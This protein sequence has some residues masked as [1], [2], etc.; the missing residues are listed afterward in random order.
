MRTKLKRLLSLLLCLVLVLNSVPLSVFAADEGGEAANAV[1]NGEYKNGTWVAGGDGTITYKGANGG[2][3][4]VLS[5]TAEITDINEFEITLQV[6]TSQTTEKAVTSAGAVVL[7]ID[8]SSSMK[9][10]AECGERDYHKSS[11]DYYVSSSSGRPGSQHNNSPVKDGQRRIDAAKEAAK[12]FLATYAGSDATADRQL[13]IVTF[14]G[15][16]RTN[17]AWANVAGGEGKNSYNTAASTINGLDCETGTIMDGGLYLAK[18]LLDDIDVTNESVVLLSDGAPSLRM[19]GGSL[20]EEWRDCEAAAAQAK[21]IRET[22]K[23]TLYTVCFGAAGQKIEDT[24]VTVDKFLEDYIA[25]PG[26]AYTAD[27]SAALLE[28]FKTIAAQIQ[29]GPL[30]GA[31]VTD[32]MGGN[33]NAENTAAENF[34]R[35]ESEDGEV[36]RWNLS[37]PETTTTT[38]GN[39][40]T[41][42]Y[43]YTC[44]YTVTLDTDNAAFEEGVF[45]PTNGETY[46]N[47]G[48]KQYAFPVP[49]VSGVETKVSVGVTKLWDDGDDQDGLRP[50]DVTV[51]LYRDGKAVEGKTLTITPNADGKWSGTFEDLPKYVEKK[52]AEYTVREVKTAEGYEATYGENDEGLVITNTHAPEQIS[53]RATKVWE[54]NNDQDGIRPDSIT[55]NLVK[56]G[57]VLESL[58][59]T[60][61]NDWTV[62]FSGY[63]KY[64]DGEEIEYTV[65]EDEVPGYEG[66]VDGYVITNT[67]EPEV[68]SVTVAKVW[69]DADNQDGKRPNDV[70][71][72]LYA[73][74]K[75]TGKTLVLNEGNEWAASFTELDKFAAGEAIAYTVQELTVEGYETEISGDMAT[76]FTITNTHIPEVV[77]VSGAKTWNDNNDQDGARPDSITINLKADGEIIETIT[78]TEEDEW[79]WSFTDLPKYEAGKLITYSITEEAVED[80]ST[81]YNGYDVTNTHT[82]EKIS[83]TVTKV[84]NDNNNQD[85]IRANSVT[86]VLMANGEETDKTLVLS[87]G[88][89]W[90]GSFTELDK[91]AAGEEIDYTVQELTVEGYE[92][93]ITGDMTTGFTITNTHTPE[94]T[95]VSGS[96]TW[97][98]N[99]DQDGARPDS[100]TINLLKN[101][102]VID[103]K[104]VTA[105]DAWSWSFTDLPKFENHGTEIVY[106]I[107]EVAV[108]GYVTEYNGFNV[109][110][111]HAPEKTSITVTKSWQDNND[112]DGIRPNDVT[113]ALLANDEDTGKT[114]VLNE[115][116]NWTGSFAELDK[117]ENGVEIKYTIE[118]FEV[119]G[120]N[121]VITGNRTDGYTITNSHTPATV[122]VSGTKTWDDADNQ[123]GK[124]P[125]S[126]TINLVV[127]D[128]VIDT[129]TVTAADKWSWSFTNLPK[130]ENHGSEIVYS[131]NET[132]VEH[133]STNY[134]GYNVTNSYTPEQTSITV[135]KSWQDNNDQDGIRPDVITVKLLADKEETGK[136]LE[137]T[138]ANNWTGSFTELDV[139]ANGQKIVYTVAE[140][141]VEKYTTVITGTAENGFVVT[142]SYTP[143]TT[144]V[145]GTKTW[146]DADDQDGARPD[147][148]TIKLLADGEVINTETVTEDN[149]WSWSFTN[150]PKYRDGGTEIV[151]A[152]TEVA[153]DKYTTTYDGYNVTNSY[154]PE[155]TG[156]TVSKS[157]QDS[158]NQD[159]IRPESVTVVLLANGEETDKTLTLSEGNKWTGTFTELDKYAAGE[160]IE[161]K[162]QELAVEGYETVISGDQYEGY[163]VTNS[164]TPETTEVSGSKTWNDNNDQDGA[165][166]DSITIHLLANGKEVDSVTV[167]AA[168]GWSWTFENLPKNEN[169]K[170]INYTVT[171]TAVEDYSTTVNGYNVTNTHTPEQTSVQVTKGW[172]DANNQDGIRPSSVT[173]KLLAN[174]KDTGKTVVLTASNKWTGTFTKLDVYANGQKIVYTVKEISVPGYTTVVSGN[175][176][177]GFVV[178]NS[179]T[180]ELVEVN[181]SKTWNDNNNQD[182]KRPN[183]IVIHLLANGKIV[184]TKVVTEADGW[185]WTFENLPKNENGKAINYT[186]L[187]DAV[188]EYVTTY[189]GY[190]VTNTHAPEK[191]AV[192]VL[193]VWADNDD[194]DGI[195]P[196]DVT[197]TLYANGKNTGKT[198]VLSEGNAW[199][200]TFVNLDKYEN[201]NVIVYTVLETEVEDYVSVIA[202][203]QTTGYLITNTHIPETVEVSGSKTWDDANNQDGKRPES[204]TVNL[205]KNGEV[206]DTKTVTEADEWSWTFE[207]LPK[208]ENHGTEIVYAITE[209]AVD[210]YSTTYDGY[211]V[212]NSYTPEQTSVTVTKAWADND[213]QDG[214]RPESVTV[215]LLKN[216]EA[217]G[218]TLVLNAENNWTGSF[219]ELDKYENGEVLAY[220]VEEVTVEGYET[221]ITGTQTDGYTITNTYT[222]E[223]VEV[224]GTK[225]WDD[226]NDQDG[227]R[228][229]SITINLLKNGE[230]IDTKTVTAEDAWSWSFTDLP[231]FENHGTEIVYAIAEVAVE[232]YSATYDGYNVTNSYTPEQTSITVTKAWADSDDADGIRPDTITIQ[233]FANGEDTGKTLVLSAED[234]WTGS[235]TELDKYADGEEIEYTIKEEAVKGYNTVIKGDAENGF[236]VTNS[237]NYIP[238]TGD[239]RNPMLWIAVM[240]MSC[241]VFLKAAFIRPKKAK[242]A[243]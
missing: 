117:Y 79:K 238:Q 204:I 132:A 65:T 55:I 199:F 17:M 10:C 3:D 82:P 139:Y 21:D 168:N 34:I 200:D 26:K 239:D 242:H 84:W 144:E 169:G 151:Y 62:T 69:N 113:V 4:L 183:A 18:D 49:G 32:P 64:A 103:T 42:T 215:N 52:L 159:G 129:K 110:N 83:V 140:E 197:V 209:V 74:G 150:L 80:Y 38:N 208:Y 108:E 180:P 187:E 222:P 88:N 177:N 66:V 243:R 40:T 234:K 233:L 223:T 157:W 207:N 25:S 57:E 155:Q 130:F 106:A 164:H 188:P 176:S 221:V 119:A 78:V 218:K 181:G 9:S 101:G 186:V 33:V 196:N 37:D 73:N 67:H 85:G 58:K 166:P 195:R 89:K 5:K 63:A 112:Q 138:A 160:E 153:V 202:G 22:A 154:T 27:S 127:G 226:N 146:D 68:T 6:T 212:T 216:G 189:K 75:D 227:K 163:I 143:E 97:N 193:K 142:N 104:T 182:G 16:Y 232:G 213:D 156:V 131:I 44:S 14:D 228:P 145:S 28:A 56:D 86:V 105:E 179:H 123:D 98:D 224:A 94:T 230:V 29:G 2:N 50:N 149:E 102:E 184:D 48:D 133:Y 236:T 13:A 23:A 20:G 148:I 147:S 219:T 135:T 35:V 93:E 100:I 96:K 162:V 141:P 201:G 134:D 77:T 240:A 7:V 194:Q 229:E 158:N 161:Y 114:L 92:T 36:Y 171:E 191:T 206:I 178:T 87:E 47:L 116:N 46:L 190:N 165:R 11:C 231:K 167:T 220:T 1:T 217:T 152:I 45:Y 128:K 121:T 225:T 51:Q 241:M 54:D 70:T 15:G 59:A 174:G 24:N 107:A 12:E 31:T 72:T 76:G 126:I 214:I 91:F 205:L 172:Q 122:D 90:T 237:H 211:N 60:A 8:T 41:V 95:E 124:R 81:T 30:S 137:L 99:N 210:E 198:V 53:I 111:T 43:T 118:E 109:I 115:G 61:K 39:V 120:Y 173:V 185:S 170:A 203:V 71:V 192:S 235:F 175:A 136:T 125:V 19:Q